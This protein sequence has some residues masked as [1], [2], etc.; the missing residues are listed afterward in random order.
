MVLFLLKK[1]GMPNCCEN[2]AVVWSDVTDTSPNLIPEVH[3]SEPKERDPFIQPVGH[4]ASE[5][6][7]KLIKSIPTE[8]RRERHSTEKHKEMAFFV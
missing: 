6:V 7:E 5:L 2:G 1:W 4:W 8:R 3:V